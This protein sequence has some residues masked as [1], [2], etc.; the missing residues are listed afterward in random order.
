MPSFPQTSLL[1][2]FAMAASTQ[3]YLHQVVPHPLLC[4]FM[5]LPP[6]KILRMSFLSVTPIAAG[7]PCFFLL[8]DSLLRDCMTSLLVWMWFVHHL[9]IERIDFFVKFCK[10]WCPPSS[11]S[12]TFSSSSNVLSSPKS[13]YYDNT[14]WTIFLYAINFLTVKVKQSLS[15]QKNLMLH[16]W[17][18]SN[19]FLQLES[20]SF[21]LLKSSSGCTQRFSC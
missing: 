2:S 8:K 1:L 7:F 9:H 12:P 10:I 20:S 21:L 17:W 16:A 18:L 14:H 4:Q 13:F 19:R 15:N 5:N 3:P 11:Y 6:N